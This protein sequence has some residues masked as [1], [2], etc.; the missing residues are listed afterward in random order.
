MAVTFFLK[1]ID[2]TVFFE[3]FWRTA[4]LYMPGGIAHLLGRLP[5]PTMLDRAIFEGAGARDDFHQLADGT[6]FVERADGHCAT[7]RDFVREVARRHRW[8]AAWCDAVS[9]LE[10]GTIGRHFDDSDNFVL[11]IEGAKRWIVELPD[12]LPEPLLKAR[13][14]GE[15]PSGALRPGRYLGSHTFEW[16]LHAGDALYLPLFFPHQGTSIGRSFSLSLVCGARS[17]LEWMS[18]PARTDFRNRD[19]CWIPAPF[20]GELDDAAAK[21]WVSRMLLECGIADREIVADEVMH[22]LNRRRAM[23]GSS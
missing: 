1:G 23:I 5:G 6:L 2:R 8:T 19:S 22:K 9:M 18:E 17:L 14:L 20:E 7:L 10:G 13:M 15:L 12:A 21:L 4:P 3:T 11:Q 16:T